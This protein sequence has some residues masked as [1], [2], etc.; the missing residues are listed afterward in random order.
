MVKIREGMPVRLLD[1]T[2]G[3]IIKAN[4]RNYDNEIWYDLRI[5]LDDAGDRFGDVIGKRVEWHGFEKDMYKHF[6]S[7]GDKNIQ[8]VSTRDFRALQTQIE[9]LTKTVNRLRG[10][11]DE[12]R[13]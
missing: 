3:Y 10:I 4:T 11:V 7:I 5:K 6:E 13:L 2:R 1:G 9:G 12:L 8:I